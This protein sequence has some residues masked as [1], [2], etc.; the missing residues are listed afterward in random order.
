MRSESTSSGCVLV[1]NMRTG[2]VESMAEKVE[3]KSC[4][5]GHE[6]PGLISIASAFDLDESII[7]NVY[8]VGSHMWGTCHK[9]SD[10]DLVVVVEKLSSAKPLNLHRRNLEAFILSFE[11]YLE[12]IQAHSLQVLV[13]LWLPETCILREKIN[14]RSK[15]QLSLAT[16][17][18]SL[19]NSKQR[20]LR[21][22]E[23]HFH[24]G[25]SKQAKKILLHSVRYVC[26][27]AQI[28]STGSICDYSSANKYREAI[29]GNY[30]TQWDELMASVQDIFDEVR[31]GL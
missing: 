12:A 13:T 20:D 10:W 8:I 21:V 3:K 1:R 15:F 24:K 16:L 11:Q 14:P 17:A 22:A 9:H 27:A 29:L 23:K 7:L 5:K 2:C 25:D 18:A 19:E 26:L 4:S 30:S 31:C 28:S 6:I